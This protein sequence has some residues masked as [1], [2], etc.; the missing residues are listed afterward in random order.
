MADLVEISRCGKLL[1]AVSTRA[2]GPRD[3]RRVPYTRAKP[4]DRIIG[5]YNFTVSR[6][7]KIENRRSRAVIKICPKWKIAISQHRRTTARRPGPGGEVTPRGWWV[8]NSRPACTCQ[9][10]GAPAIGRREA[11]PES[12]RPVQYCTVLELDQ[13]YSRFR[14]F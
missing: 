3:R 12:F 4:C 6:N 9:W 2:A 11:A 13:I 14:I 1:R 7:P 8:G 10:A 5:P